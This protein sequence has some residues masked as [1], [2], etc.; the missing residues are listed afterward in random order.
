MKLSG[1]K[2]NASERKSL[3]P[4]TETVDRK[5]ENGW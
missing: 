5:K 4:F 1:E 2:R 3:F